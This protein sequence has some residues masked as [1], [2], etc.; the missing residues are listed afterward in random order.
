MEATPSS[1]M[2]FIFLD[3]DRLHPPARPCHGRV[4]LTLLTACM[5]RLR[6]ELLSPRTKTL[7]TSP[8]QPYALAFCLLSIFSIFIVELVAFR[9]GTAKLA[10]LGVRHG[11]SFPL[12]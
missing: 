4:E 7:L 12:A 11:I 6:S 10:A 5:A 1:L 8:L 3:W 2:P 9:W